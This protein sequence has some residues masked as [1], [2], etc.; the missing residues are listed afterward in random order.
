M[1][2]ADELVAVVV[3]V[4][5]VSRLPAADRLIA[6]TRKHDPHIVIVAGGFAVPD[7]PAAHSLG[8]DGWTAD[9]RRLGGLIEDLAAER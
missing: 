1:R 2:G 5:D 8:A 9:P 6:A 3:S 4:A 7:E